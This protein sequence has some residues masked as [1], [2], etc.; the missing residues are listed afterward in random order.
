MALSRTA[1]LVA[2]I[3]ASAIAVVTPAL[4]HAQEARPAALPAPRAS[5]TPA[6]VD[7]RLQ[8]ISDPAARANIAATISAASDRGLPVE[9]LVTKALEGVEKGAA[10]TRIESAVQAMA[11]RLATASQALAPVISM[12]ELESGADALGAGVPAEVLRGIRAVSMGRSSAVALGVVA[13]LTARGVPATKAGGAVAALVK[14]GAS[15][16]HLQELQR[17]VQEDLAAGLPPSS[18]LDLRVRALTSALP[19]TLP[20]TAATADALTNENFG[21]PTPRPGSPTPPKK[22]P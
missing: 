11:R 15:S 20:A 7:E 5:M 19:P 12:R 6:E 10:P 13:Q 9:P 17:L 21:P 14:R 16:A 22:R 3:A 18:A 2:A 1:L 8:A 4:A